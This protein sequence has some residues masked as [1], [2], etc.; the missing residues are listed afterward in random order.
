MR[1]IICTAMMAFV[2]TAAGAQDKVAG[3]SNPM[4]TAGYKWKCETTAR[5]TC[6]RDGSCK[7]EARTGSFIVDYENNRFEFDGQPVRIKRHYQQR[8][9]NSP[10]Q[11]EVKVELNDNRV[12]WLT[13]VDGS[14][15]YSSAWVGALIEPKGGVVLMTNDNAYCVPQK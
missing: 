9:A 11:G 2:A 1:T 3:S 12:L 8:I 15:T 6:E 4:W 5:I 14:Y 10:L 13:A 7:T